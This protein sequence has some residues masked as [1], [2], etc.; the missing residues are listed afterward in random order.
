M[1]FRRVSRRDTIF[2]LSNEMELIQVED[3]KILIF[4]YRILRPDIW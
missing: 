1:D 3:W 4:D 2:S